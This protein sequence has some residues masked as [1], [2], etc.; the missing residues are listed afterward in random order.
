MKNIAIVL[1]GGTGS[2]M[3]LDK[4]KQFVEIEGRSVIE[5]SIDAFE[6]A[7][8]ID[9]VVAVVHP[10]WMGYMHALVERNHWTKMGPLV[11]GGSERYMSSLNAVAALM[12]EPDDTNLIFH[13]AARPWVSQEVIDRVLEALAKYE[14]VGVGIP[15]IDTIW[16]VRTEFDLEAAGKGKPLPKFVTRIPERNQMWRA[17]TPQ[18]FR[19]PIIRDAYQRALQDAQFKATDDCGVVRRYMPEVK[20]HVVEGDEE[21]K[22]ITFKTD[23]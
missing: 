8:G 12:N 10:D 9:Q 19:L 23:L 5:R 21:N 1:A 13:D 17:Q 15:S 11:E 2:R 4:P 14:A 22:K 3:G 20:I 18:A 16:E 7:T 6:Q